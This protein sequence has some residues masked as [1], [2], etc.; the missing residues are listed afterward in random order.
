MGWTTENSE[1]E[2]QQGEDIYLFSKESRSAPEPIQPPTQQIPSPP[3]RDKAARAEAN[4]S[5][6]CNTKVKHAWDNTSTPTCIYS[7][8]L[9]YE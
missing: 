7:V 2:S 5:C 4:H 1:F 6:L 9:D 8:V 3:S